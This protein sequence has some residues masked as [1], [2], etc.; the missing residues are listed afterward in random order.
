MKRSVV[1]LRD[2]PPALRAFVD[3]TTFDGQQSEVKTDYCERD[4]WEPG[5]NYGWFACVKFNGE[6]AIDH[7]GFRSTRS[8]AIAALNKRVIEIA[9]AVLRADGYE[10]SL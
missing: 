2:L 10:M 3:A 4:S 9:S 7:E 1:S 8:E 5:S 6:P